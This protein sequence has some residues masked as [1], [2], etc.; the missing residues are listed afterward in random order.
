MMNC[1]TEKKNRFL[2]KEVVG[3]Y[4]KKNKEELLTTTAT[5]TLTGVI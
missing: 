4:Q 1:K 3:V 5:V 2:K